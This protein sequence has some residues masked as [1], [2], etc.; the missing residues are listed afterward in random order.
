MQAY[1]TEKILPQNGLLILDDLPFKA[2]DVIEII[3]LY[4]ENK[5][6]KHCYPLRGKL[7]EYDNP[8]EPVAIEDWEVL[9]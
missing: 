7:I 8:F 2:N 4:K 1:K 6:E 3:I 5:D 9:K